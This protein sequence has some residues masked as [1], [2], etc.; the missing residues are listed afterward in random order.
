[1][2]GRSG[3]SLSA[4]CCPTR[5]TTCWPPH[6][7]GSA[8]GPICRFAWSA[9]ARKS[10]ALAALRRLD[11]VVVENRW[12][13]EDAVG[14][15]LAWADALVLSHTEA[16]QSGVAAAAISARRWVVAT[17]VGGF[18]EQLA[19][20][21]LARLCEP[22]PESLAAAL[23]G[24]LENPPEPPPAADPQTAWRGIATTLA[25]HIAA[26]LASR[27]T[28]KADQAGLAAGSIQPIWPSPR[29]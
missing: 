12:V 25:R 14:A 21:K 26:V 10:A 17:R 22:T 23:R 27:G 1:M 16:S 5:G 24:L 15:L 13:A 6:W 8:R 18:A 2:A 3:C 29:R 7:S 11:G 4:A 9:A 20:E 19:G 28:G